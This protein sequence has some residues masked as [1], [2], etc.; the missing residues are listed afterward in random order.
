MTQRPRIA[1]V[2]M[3]FRFAGARNTAEFWDLLFKGGDASRLVPDGR[4]LLPPDAVVEP[5]ALGVIDRVPAARGYF[6]D[7]EPF[8][9][10]GLDLDPDLLG[11]LDPLFRLTANVGRDAFSACRSGDLDRRRVGLVIGNI[12]LPSEHSSRLAREWLGAA[13]IEQATGQAAPAPT[14]LAEDAF[15]A[16]LPALLLA[17]GLGLGGTV[18]TLDAACASSLYALKIAAREL[19][20]GRADAMITGG[21]SRPDALYTQMG[22]AQLNALAPDGISRPFDAG[23]SGLVVGEGAGFFV[24]KR[25]ADAR[26]QGDEILGVLSGFGLSND[27]GG[28][29]MAPSSEG[30]LRAMRAAYAEAGWQPSD[31]DMI[32]CHAT[33]TPL[34]DQVEAESLKQ[35]W[36]GVR[37]DRRCVLGSV[38]ANVGHLLTA[39]GAS[40]LVKVLLALR[41]RTLLP[42][43]NF[44]A[45]SPRLALNDSPFSVL[46]APQAWPERSRDVPRRAAV[47]GFGFGGINAHVL[48][49]EWLPERGHELATPVQ[50]APPQK[51]VAVIGVGIQRAGATGERAWFGAEASTAYRAAFGDEAFA[52]A[53]A[54]TLTVPV[55][56][57]R[58]PPAELSE[59]LPQQLLMLLAARTAVEQARLGRDAKPDAG[60]FVG[61]ALDGA[62]NHHSCR[63]ML[64]D[65]LRAAFGH[66][67]TPSRVMGALGGIV[68]S[69]VARAFGF[70]GLGFTV[71]SEETS[72]LK[73]LTLGVRA[74]RS[75]DLRVALVGAV[76]APAHFLAS[77]ARRL[78][79]RDEAPLLGA[80]DAAIALI[81]K[82]ADAAHNDGDEILAFVD[83]DSQ[84]LAACAE[85]LQALPRTGVAGGLLR[86]AEAI[87]SLGNGLFP[88]PPDYWLRNREDGPRRVAVHARGP[89][90]WRDHATVTVEAGE[91]RIE[92]ASV[93]QQRYALFTLAAATH[94][95]L[96]V[97]FEALTSK[98]AALP[99]S[100]WRGAAASGWDSVQAQHACRLSLLADFHTGRTAETWLK[101]WRDAFASDRGFVPEAG[102]YS[103]NAPTTPRLA[104]VFPGAGSHYRNMGRELAAAFPALMERQDEDCAHLRTQWGADAFWS[105]APR[106][107]T[108]IEVL[109]GQCALAALAVDACAAAGLRPDAAIGYSL[110]ESAALVAL[111][112]WDHRDEVFERLRVSPLFTT[113]LAGPMDAVRRHWGLAA[114]EPLKWANYLVRRSPADVRA[115]LADLPRVY[116]NNINT[117]QECVIGGDANQAA[118]AVARLRVPPLPL[119]AIPALHCPVVREVEGDFLAFHR[120]ALTAPPGVTFYSGARGEALTLTSEAAAASIL[121]H[122]AEGVDFPA[123]VEAAYRDG[124]RLFVEVGPGGGATRMVHDILGDRPHF[125]ASLCPREGQEL[126]AYWRVVA[127]CHAL[128][129][130]LKFDRH[131][132]IEDAPQQVNASGPLIHVSVGGAP[133]FASDATDASIQENLNPARVA[134]HEAAP[135]G[136]AVNEAIMASDYSP[137]SSPTTA[138]AAVLPEA[139]TALLA[140]QA[141]TIE[142][143]SAYM[144]ASQSALAQALGALAAQGP[145]VYAA[146]TV[147]APVA[148]ARDVS[149]ASWDLADRAPFNLEPAWL[150]FRACQSLASGRLSDAFGPD[151]A[152]VDSYP[153]RVR[154]PDGPLLLCHRIMSVEAVP[155]SMTHGRLVT[156]HDVHADAWY[157]DDGR[158]PTCVAVEAGQ[159]DLVLSGY[160]GA[161]FETKG[162]SVY[163]LLDAVVTFHDRLPE[164]GATIRYDIKIHHFFRQGATILFRFSFEATCN[165]Q[166]LITMEQG[167]A[168]F[169]SP[170]ELAAG[171]GIVKTKLDLAPRAGKVTGGFTTPVPLKREAFTA[172]Q[173]DALRQGDYAGCFGEAFAA[174]P[175]QNPKTL[176]GGMLRLVHRIVSIEPQGGRF[177]LGAITGEADVRD[178]DWFLTCHFVDDRVMPGTLMYEC[179]NH[180][181]RV[182]LMRMGWVGEAADLPCEP[183]PGVAS[184]LKCRGQVVPG[185]RVVTYQIELKEIGYGPDAYAIADALM[186]VDGKAVVEITDMSLRHCG[187]TRER[188]ESLW[189]AA[190]KPALYGYERILAFSNGKPSEAFGAPY[191]IFDGDDGSGRRI[192]RLPR[193]P[194]QFLDRVTKADSEPFA[195][196]AGGTIEAAYDVPADAWYFDAGGAGKTMP[197]A[198]LL[199]AALQ[200]CGWFS[201]Y[202]GSALRSDTDLAYRNLGGKAV[203]LRPVTPDSGTLTTRVVATKVSQSAGMI[204]QEFTF[205]VSDSAGLVYEGETMFGFF[206]ADALAKQVGLRGAALPEGLNKGAFAT[207]PERGALPRAPMLMVDHV[208][209]LSLGAGGKHGLGHVHGRKAVNPAEWFFEAH[210]YQDPVMPGSLG[211]EAG[212]QL[213]MLA[214]SEM[215]PDAAGFQAVTCGETH[216]WTYRGQVVPRNA[217]TDV[218][219][220]ITAVDEAKRV[221]RGDGVLLVDGLP[222]YE[223]KGFSVQALLRS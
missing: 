104:F 158:I 95:D 32:E 3:S 116:L 75:G 123:T 220:D 172:A 219:M 139:L 176:P 166:R 222:I 62:T 98:L 69:R 133:F 23:A 210:F 213:L 174:L 106:S 78:V 147:V 68:A 58:T 4:W 5:G 59:L 96:N 193:P 204:I 145:E 80:E 113:E 205:H 14:T 209:S 77:T 79:W 215:W 20:E 184:R 167:C 61:I 1:I 125:A 57:F 74:I 63:W 160:L 19:Q 208:V 102:F 97:A 178:D 120:A 9:P 117:P 89:A 119:F 11:R 218:V 144:R 179:C 55:A 173:L 190:E 6:L 196:L 22:F 76:D 169:F 15:V 168:G 185:A 26:A 108:Q 199:E 8:D 112:A 34:G 134:A 70:G 154:L 197:F 217:R 87:A 161:D 163:R 128:G 100:L 136:V 93:L 65:E 107:P 150:D 142:V 13:F 203:Q 124:V 46:P 111:R 216:S 60:V 85:T 137:A 138:P 91:R 28:S 56:A 37:S 81:L 155:R 71:S 221:V 187:L 86:V 72:G 51:R 21:V 195:M 7:D 164:P 52:A 50:V 177:G 114:G 143:H 33:G 54:T 53:M 183:I 103:A 42:T 92:T 121:A 156:E 171:R 25:L 43:A 181:L 2:S 64:S 122:A 126:G 115:V 49:E 39:A 94:S 66:E 35:L 152:V 105:S 141:R 88:E 153:T 202:M 82:D 16:G 162:E 191:K 67:L 90:A 129:R 17:K 127:A 36:S 201:A 12:A 186:F 41:Q 223:M 175:L 10:R 207:Y 31:V 29:L 132:F 214:A 200:P 110:G 140:A 194:Y 84:G 198:V 73:A 135:P 47:S 109:G 188:V 159:A 40:S 38:K 151:F 157:L 206:S 44:V 146:G 101:L 211:L 131:L 189:G 24:L 130:A 180:T 170:E 83:D 148:P 149:K 45:P 48:V 18:L 165:G 99:L 192:A 118:Q 27:V 212:L 30:Q 182:L